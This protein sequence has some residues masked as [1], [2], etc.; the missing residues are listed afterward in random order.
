MENIQSRVDAL[1]ENYFSDGFGI[2]DCHGTFKKC[3]GT[4]HIRLFT[5]VDY[6]D[7]RLLLDIREN[8]IETCVFQ[9]KA[10]YA[11]W[12]VRQVKV[13]CRRV[14]TIAPRVRPAGPL[15]AGTL[16]GGVPV[17]FVRRFTQIS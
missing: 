12:A 16:A 3:H 1:P 7:Q 9:L 5:P 15:V 13:R 4:W 11:A 14:S 6:I 10:F 8:S 17:H 2:E